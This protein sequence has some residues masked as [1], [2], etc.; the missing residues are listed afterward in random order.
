LK[1][2][3]WVRDSF[4]LAARGA[5]GIG[6]S[7][8]TP[9]GQAVNL[10]LT[11][12]DPFEPT[13]SLRRPDP[14]EW[15]PSGAA[16]LALDQQRLPV[17]GTSKGA[18]GTAAVEGIVLPVGFDQFSQGIVEQAVGPHVKE[19]DALLTVSMDGRLMPSDPIRLEHYAVGVHDIGG[20]TEGVPAAV[21]GVFGPAII[22]S[23]A[24]LQQIASGTE[25][26]AN[27]GAPGI[28]KPTT[29]EDITFRFASASL[30]D[31]ALKGLGLPAQGS[32]RVVISDAKAIQTILTTMKRI[33]SGPNIQFSAG[34]TSF[35]ATVV[36]GPGGSFLSN[37]VSY[38]AQR[39]LQTSGSPSDQLS[40]HVHTPSG[41]AIPQATGTATERKAKSDAQRKAM[42]LRDLLVQTLNRLI[43]VVAGLI[44]DRRAAKSSAT[45]TGKAKTP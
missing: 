43:G 7:K 33:V 21:G 1:H 44:L 35:Q 13:G 25:Q 2:L 20:K 14:G 9:K 27:G 12:F 18:K 17:A 3:Q 19:L 32:P 38:R 8:G 37:E 4:E 24:P 22:E 15:N 10:L 45:S 28:Q 29:G 34:G 30:A 5:A 16:V 39:L 31:A 40:F 36:E 26:T 41:E 42:G 23:N 6:F 11:G